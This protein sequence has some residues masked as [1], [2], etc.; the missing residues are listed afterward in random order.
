MVRAMHTRPLV[1]EPSVWYGCTP[2]LSIRLGCH[3]CNVSGHFRCL[4]AR[5][6]ARRLRQSH[7]GLGGRQ[8]DRGCRLGVG[9]DVCGGCHRRLWP[10]QLD[11][12]PR[13]AFGTVFP[14]SVRLAWSSLAR[15]REVPRSDTSSKLLCVAKIRCAYSLNFG[16]LSSRAHHKPGLPLAARPPPWA[17]PGGLF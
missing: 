9:Q 3:A 13:P 2:T 11:D 10:A 16:V 1:C 8:G 17:K 15:G 7:E 6:Q 5:R 14:C 4:Q 12:Q